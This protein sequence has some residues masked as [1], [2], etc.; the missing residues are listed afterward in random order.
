M[1]DRCINRFEACGYSTRASLLEDCEHTYND[2][3]G[4]K[5]DD[6]IPM[7]L[8]NSIYKI[9]QDMRKSPS[10]VST[11]TVASSPPEKVRS[12]NVSSQILLRISR[13]NVISSSGKSFI[14][15]GIYAPKVR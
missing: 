5:K 15:N 6:Q 4:L 1:V 14:L 13:K 11:P 10:I 3:L 2:D 12:E 9:I 8:V 7:R